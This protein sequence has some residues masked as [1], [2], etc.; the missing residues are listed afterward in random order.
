LC[1]R[2]FRKSAEVGLAETVF[3]FVSIAVLFAPGSVGAAI[4]CT[5]GHAGLGALASLA[6]LPA[7]SAALAIFLPVVLPPIAWCLGLPVRTGNSFNSADTTLYPSL[8]NT[9]GPQAGGIQR[10]LGRQLLL[11]LMLMVTSKGVCIAL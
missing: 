3:V 2:D 8:A 9:V 7:L 1:Q 10:G 11:V 4:A 6:L 5:A